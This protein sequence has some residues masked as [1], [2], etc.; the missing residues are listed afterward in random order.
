[1]FGGGVFFVCLFGFWVDVEIVGEMVE[2]VE[3]CCYL[4]DVVNCDVVLVGFV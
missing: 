1:M 3:E 4:G 2:V